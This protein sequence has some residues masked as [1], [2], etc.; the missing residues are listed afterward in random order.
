MSVFTTVTP[1]QLSAWLKNYSIG[2]LTDL[3][4]IAAGIENTNYFVTTT[5][6]RF[7]LTLFEKLKPAEL[8]F[9]L[10][11]MAHLVQSRNPLP[12]TDCKSAERISWRAERKTCRHRHLFERCTGV[13]PHSRALRTRGRGIG[14]DALVRPD[15]QRSIGKPPRPQVVGG[16]RTGDLPV[17][18]R[19]RCG[20]ATKRNPLPG[21]ASS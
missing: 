21:G 20:T 18:F 10:E 11:L 7:V 2:L 19:R 6:G 12:Q 9:Y 13:G 8:P 5:H 14:G 16:M 3:Q 4:G 15:V 1:D 17:S